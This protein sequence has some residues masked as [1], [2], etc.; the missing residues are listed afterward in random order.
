MKERRWKK[1]MTY[2]CRY[3]NFI[4]NEW[5]EDF[6]NVLVHEK[7]HKNT[8]SSVRDFENNHVNVTKMSST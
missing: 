4:W 8:R 6:K 5:D 3:C 2:N 7:T 1:L